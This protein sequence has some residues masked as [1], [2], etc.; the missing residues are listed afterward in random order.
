MANANLN[1]TLKEIDA[2]IERYKADMKMGEALERLKKNEDFQNII[3]NGY[4]E[5]EAEKLFNIL[6]DPSGAS[7]YSE[8]TI[9]LKLAAISHLRSF[10][11]TEKFEGTIEMNAKRAP[12][13]I[14]KE[15][16]FRL[17]ITADA[18]TGYDYE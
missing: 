12:L 18:A 7:P 8:E 9:K 2:A 10:I 14:A 4:M 16:D 1:D 11:G 3:L 17:E 6:I 13:A 5:V 15:E